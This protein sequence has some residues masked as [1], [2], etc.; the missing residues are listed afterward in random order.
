MTAMDIVI[1]D[2]RNNEQ[3]QLQFSMFARVGVG[4]VIPAGAVENAVE[5]C[6]HDMD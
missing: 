6:L 2:I 1:R 5:V 3:G 4:A